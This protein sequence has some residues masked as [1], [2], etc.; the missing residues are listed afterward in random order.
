MNDALFHRGPDDEGLHRSGRTAI[1]M[2]RLA[3]ID[4]AGGHQ[5]MTS[6]DGRF[7]IVFNGEIYNYRSLRDELQR[8]GARFETTSDTEV[9]LR[10]FEQRGPSACQRLNGMFAFCVIDRNDGSLFL[11]RDQYGQKPLFYALHD[12]R[13]AFSSEIPSLLEDPDLPRDADLVAIA[14]YLRFA[15]I[16]SPRTILA[17]V[18]QL[19]PAHWMRVR[20]GEI[21]TAKFGWDGPGHGA[22]I[23][24]DHEAVES[25]REALLDSVQRHLHAD[26]PVACFLSGGIDSA[27]IVAAAVQR[28]SRPVRTFTVR[29]VDS[30]RDESAVARSVAAHLGTEHA[31][32]PIETGSFDADEFWHIVEHLSQPFVDSSVLPTYALT[33]EMR[34]HVPVAISGDGGDEVFGGYNEYGH[35]QSL[36]AASTLLNPRFAAAALRTLGTVRTAPGMHNLAPLRLTHRALDALAS[37]NG[38]APW[39]VNNLMSAEEYRTLVHPA[40]PPAPVREI[41]Q[42]MQS[43]PQDTPLRE[44]MAYRTSFILADQLLPKVDRMSMAHSLEVR[45]PLLDQRIGAVA[46][47]LQDSHLRRDG[48]GKWV[49]R[50]IVAEWVPA[51][52][53][54]QPKQ[55][56]D[57][58]LT[59]VRNDAFSALCRDLI[60]DPTNEVMGTVF[61]REQLVG[62]VES[63]L[64]VTADTASVSAQR[65]SRWLWSALILAAWSKRYGLTIAPADRPVQ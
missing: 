22:P 1:A 47:R 30:P 55:G 46:A 6:Q 26:V 18:R 65:A 50:K 51:E 10:L 60:L 7:T 33:R 2:R 3:I 49:M 17:S 20:G 28:S 54:R 15:S 29:W 42:L 62:I 63:G 37:E 12:G 43:W 64:T 40:M 56:F 31:E 36:A 38:L 48:K 58:P 11:A 24:D 23:T 13:F 32:L 34:K 45:A 8:S 52:V 5:P 9:I 59:A 16:P 21:V 41:E 25:V 27:A 19:P 35:Y 57:A 44:I 14:H 53:L 4:L 39:N 61:H